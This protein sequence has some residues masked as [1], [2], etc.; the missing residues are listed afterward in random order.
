MGTQGLRNE[1]RGF[2]YFGLRN[3]YTFVFIAF[4]FRFKGV[5]LA[6]ALTLETTSPL[7]APDS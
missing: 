1:T 4:S 7:L 6:R 2:R 3:A 5:M